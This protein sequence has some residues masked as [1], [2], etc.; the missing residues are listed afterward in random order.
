MPDVFRHATAEDVPALVELAEQRRALYAQ[1]Q[2]VF[3]R[4]AADAREQ[5]EPYLRSLLTHENVI[6][7]VH[8]RID[9]TVDGFAL[10]TLAPSPPVYNPGGLTCFIDDLGVLDAADWAKTGQQLLTEATTEAKARRAN[11]VVVVCGHLDQ[12]KRAM[13]AAAGLSI[14]S[15]WYVRPL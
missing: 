15:E 10:A 3:W 1:Y 11:Q 8:E 5:H 9:G 14:A 4:P 13:I 12:P 2:P 7:P 6:A